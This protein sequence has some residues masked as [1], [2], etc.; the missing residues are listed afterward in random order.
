MYNIYS[1][2]H[3]P[4]RRDTKEIPNG[5]K[6]LFSYV[7]NNSCLAQIVYPIQQNNRPASN[8]TCIFQNLLI[9]NCSL[10]MGF[11]PHLST[12]ADIISFC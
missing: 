3:L 1:E 8:Q 5:D 4:G 7:L 10:G 12:Q 2:E 6:P 9:A 11:P